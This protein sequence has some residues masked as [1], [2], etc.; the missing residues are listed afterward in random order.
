M[1]EAPHESASRYTRALIGNAT[2][3]FFDRPST[4]EALARIASVTRSSAEPGEHEYSPSTW[5]RQGL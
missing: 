2:F 4:I 1:I 5:P 3:I